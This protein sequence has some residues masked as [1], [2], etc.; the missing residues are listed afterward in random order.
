M[1][2]DL[3]F[4]IAVPAFNEEESIQFVLRDILEIFDIDQIV[5]VDD[6]S[7]DSTRELVKAQGI[8]II[9]LP[10]NTGVGGA[11]RTAFKF[12]ISNGFDAVVQIDADGQHDPRFITQLIGHLD[13]SDVVI[14]SRFSGLGKYRTIGPR[15]WAMRLLA[16]FVSLLTGKRF[17]DVT[18]GFRATGPKALGLFSRHYPV[19]YLGDTVESIVLAHRAG[20]NVVEVPVEM[21]HRQ[22][23]RP[24]QSIVQATLFLFRAFLVL[25][26]A[27]IRPRIK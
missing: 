19:E 23:G 5:V 6:G 13:K 10:F 4:L 15:R 27:A 22:G 11:M 3:K 14:G 7:S 20:L 2:P 18:S 9:S 17:N 25:I 21:R 12:A 8:R 16:R 26:L 1:K 24:S